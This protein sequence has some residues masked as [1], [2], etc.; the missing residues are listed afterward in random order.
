MGIVQTQTLARMAA[1]EDQR[2]NAV[3]NLKTLT[4]SL[5]M[6]FDDI[7]TKLDEFISRLGSIPPITIPIEYDI[8][9]GRG[10]PENTGRAPGTEPPGVPEFAGGSYGI[11]DFGSGT[12]AMLHGREGVFTESQVRQFGGDG[13]G[14]GMVVNIHVAGSVTSERDLADTISRHLDDRYRLHNKVRAA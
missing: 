9:D 14:G 6:G 7:L 11:R 13:A 4:D 1:I 3:D 2:E 5:G 8:P 10:F 12:L